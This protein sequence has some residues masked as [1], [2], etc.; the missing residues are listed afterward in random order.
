ML[1]LAPPISSLAR[2]EIITESNFI[3]E[4]KGQAAITTLD[5]KTVECLVGVTT[6][7]RYK[8]IGEDLG[9]AARSFRV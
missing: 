9:D 6:A 1:S 8:Q 2:Y 4:R 3:G 5:G 7:A